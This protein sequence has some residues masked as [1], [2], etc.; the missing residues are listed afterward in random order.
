MTRSLGADALPGPLGKAERLR[1]GREIVIPIEVTFV[2]LEVVEDVAGGAWR[3][4]RSRRTATLSLPV[5]VRNGLVNWAP[6]PTA[7]QTPAAC[8]TPSMNSPWMASPLPEKARSSVAPVEDRCR[9]R[10]RRADAES[11]WPA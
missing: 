9:E 10:Q 1:D 7:P 6:D 8:G 11:S 2:D 4:R 5:P 3:L